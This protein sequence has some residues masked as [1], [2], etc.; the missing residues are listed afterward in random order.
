MP[1]DILQGAVVPVKLWS[2][3]AHVEESAQKQLK[4]VAALPWCFSHV[5]VMPDVHFGIGC[6][7]GSVIAMRDAIVPSAV[8]VDIGCVDCETEYLSPTGWKRIDQYADDP[9][10]EYDPETGKA[11]FRQP[12]A[13]V[14]LPCN[15]FYRIKTKYGVDQ[16][17]SA[18]H[19][20]LYVRY[21]RTYKF[22]V[23]Q[24]IL[25]SDLAEWHNAT[26]SG[27]RG[28]FITTFTPELAT[29]VYMSDED[30]RIAVMVAADA[31]VRNENTGNC[32]LHFKKQRKI[33]RARQLLWDADIE[34]S[35]HANNDETVTISFTAPV[36]PG[37][38][39]NLRTLSVYWAASLDQLRVIA[40]EVFHWDGSLE[41]RCY[42]TR[43][44]ASADFISYAFAATGCRSVMRADDG[45]RDGHNPTGKLDYRVFAQ[46]NVKVGIYGSPKTPIE[47][48]PSADG[49][50][51]CFTTG[52][53]YW[54]MRR[55]GN[56]AAT[57]NCGMA[58]VKTNLTSH[59]LPHDLKALRDQIERDIPTG[60][61]AHTSSYADPAHGGL[62]DPALDA[63]TSSL[64]ERFKQGVRAPVQDSLDHAVQQI[65]TLGGGNHFIELC[66]DTS[67][68]VWMMLHSGS[69][70]IGN[71]IATYHIAQAKSLLHNQDL[72]DPD[73]AAFLSGTPGMEAYQHDLY[74]AQEYAAHNRAVMLAL[75]RR[76]IR[77]FFKRVEFATPIQCHH[78]YVAAETH[79]GENVLVTRKGA[80]R[81]GKGDLGI[82][83]GSM[84]TRSYIVRGLGNPDSFESASHGAG[85]K[86]SRGQA[87]RTFTVQDLEA[88]TQGVECRKDASVLDEIPSAYKSI[89][90]VMENQRDLVEIVHE[91]RGVL[92]VKGGDDRAHRG[93]KRNKP[94]RGGVRES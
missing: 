11:F 71:K 5:A 68:R 79:F 88:L 46:D 77:R 33:E 76:A 44:K 12:K 13:Y 66:L 75:Y 82:I 90:T 43:D 40:S 53:G 61:H 28:R 57:G 73:L 51:Y 14:K 92:C 64:V 8:G 56:I 30:L 69:R 35:E 42:Y 47:V 27:F 50:K 9:I 70:G 3:L 38:Y 4:N 89:E 78:N 81:A 74:W 54:I 49:Y 18:E 80:I 91:L 15:E 17:L 1:I 59:D 32:V 34:F 10:M 23:V 19:R 25:A 93:D 36:P 72:P 85:R 67:D 86:M 83:P 22:N 84:G 20:V 24:T 63:V 41:D 39:T 2:P 52:T 65:G 87:K 29:R 7:V 45:K 37:G 16:K 58:A 55:G 94:Q 6:T 62:Q 21:D 48:E 31:H 60:F 26:K